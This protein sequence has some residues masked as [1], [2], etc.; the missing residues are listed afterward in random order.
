MYL[1]DVRFYLVPDMENESKKNKLIFLAP[2]LCIIG[3]LALLLSGLE[4]GEKTI[5]ILAIA[6][7]VLALISLGCFL[8]DRIKEKHR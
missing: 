2:L 5:V 8:Y 3:G 7:L 6:V 4:S 1:C